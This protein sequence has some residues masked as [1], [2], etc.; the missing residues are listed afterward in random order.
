MCEGK[1][2]SVSDKLII[3]I[4]VIKMSIPSFIRLVGIGSKSQDLHGARRTRR[5]TS[6]AVTQV[7]FCQTSL[8]SGGFNPRRCESEEKEE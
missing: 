7:R 6:L 2:P 1:K 4:C 3:D 5:G 8:V